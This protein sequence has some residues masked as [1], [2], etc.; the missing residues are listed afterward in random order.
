MAAALPP[1]PPLRPRPPFLTTCASLPSRHPRAPPRAGG[2]RTG[3][4]AANPVAEPWRQEALVIALASAAAVCGSDLDDDLMWFDFIHLRA[5]DLISSCFCCATLRGGGGVLTMGKQKAAMAGKP[6]P[7]NTHHAL[8]DIGNIEANNQ[9][10]PWAT[11][12]TSSTSSRP[13][14]G[15]KPQEAATTDIRPYNIAHRGSNGEIPEETTATY[16]RAIEE[17]ADFIETDIL[18][19]K[20]GHLIC[21]HDVILDTTIDI[22][23][24]TEFTGRKRTYDVQGVKLTGWFI[25]DFTLRE[26][27][28]LRVKQRYNFR[29][30]QYN[31]KYNI[32][33]FDE[34]ILIALH[35]DRV[36]GIYPEIK[37]PIFIKHWSRGKK[38][39]DKF[40][41]TLLKYGYK[42]EYMSK[43][44]LKKPLFILSF[45]PTSL[46]YISNMTNAPK[47]LLIYPTTVPTEDTNQSY[48]EIT[49][50]G[51]LAFIRNTMLNH[52]GVVGASIHIRNE[53]SFLHF[54]FHQD[55][56]AEYEYWLREIGVDAL[57]TDFTSSLHKYQEWTAPHQRKEKKCTG[58]P[59]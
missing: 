15:C 36:V 16:L 44:W 32:L 5:T 37:N 24:R 18:A 6:D 2:W 39:E 43:D 31:W 58:T 17:G 23:N 19:S 27:K 35:A 25:V 11:L 54:N 13:K 1:R 50:N 51:Y 53:N 57:F 34:F 3:D 48:Y 22:A 56:Y 29:D 21:S 38:F 52:G 41:E 46:I 30:Q 4:T 55:P 28:S 49:S 8:G 47:L 9:R 42:G 10:A 12:P 33:T 20:D 45:A 14:S 59:A 26:L 7:K 40:V